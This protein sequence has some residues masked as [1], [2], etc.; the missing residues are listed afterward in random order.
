MDVLYKHLSVHWGNAEMHQH[1]WLWHINNSVPKE[2]APRERDRKCDRIIV[3]VEVYLF[4]GANRDGTINAEMFASWSWCNVDLMKPDLPV[5]SFLGTHTVCTPNHTHA[6]PSAY[7]YTLGF[8]SH[9]WTC[10]Y[11]EK[12]RQHSYTDTGQEECH[13]LWWDVTHA[14]CKYNLYILKFR[15]LFV[16]LSRRH[17][18]KHNV[19]LCNLHPMACI[20]FFPLHFLLV[21]VA[22]WGC[23]DN[24]MRRDNLCS[25]R[26]P[27]YKECITF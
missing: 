3:Y 24:W 25:L 26:S 11:F 6:R 23:A 16:L 8:W 4:R 17:T 15:L 5:N 22:S 20:A 10:S 19:I 1:C 7:M 12:S 27:M 18:E 13:V 14:K 9:K 2:T 21:F